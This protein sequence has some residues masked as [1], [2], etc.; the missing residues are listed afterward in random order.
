MGFVFQGEFAKRVLLKCIQVLL[1][2][3]GEVAKFKP[4]SAESKIIIASR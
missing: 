4:A 1:K 2:S 3:Y